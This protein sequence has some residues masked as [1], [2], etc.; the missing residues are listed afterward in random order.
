MGL[1][2][3]QEMEEWVAV[4]GRVLDGGEAGLRRQY[5]PVHQCQHACVICE[6]IHPRGRSWLYGETSPPL[7]DW[8]Q[9]LGLLE[10][11][12]SYWRDEETPP[13]HTH[14]SRI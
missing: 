1:D 9:I 7:P 5:Q 10:S 12:W 13:P 14:K 4:G 3:G 11:H 6:T 2:E 8:F